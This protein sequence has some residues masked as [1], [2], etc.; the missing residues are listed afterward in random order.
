M[1]ADRDK[2][3]SDVKPGD[4]A[5]IPAKMGLGGRLRNYFI[6]GILV[7]APVGITLYLAWI[8]I[9]FVDNQVTP[10]IPAKYNP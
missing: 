10:L 9:E 6:A 1:T 2:P 7:T 4:E 8:F 3:Q 5:P